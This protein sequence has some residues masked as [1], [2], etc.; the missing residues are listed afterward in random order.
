MNFNFKNAMFI[1]AIASFIA[2]TFI[3]FVGEHQ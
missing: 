1:N 2:S 3:Y